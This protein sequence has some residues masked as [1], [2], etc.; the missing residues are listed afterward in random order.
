MKITLDKSWI[1]WYNSRMVGKL[2]NKSPWPHS[3]AEHTSLYNDGRIRQVA[4]VLADVGKAH[5]PNVR[6]PII[7]GG[8]IRDT[9][10]G[11][12]YKDIDVFFDVSS[13]AEDERDDAV[14]LYASYVLDALKKQDGW[15]G[16]KLARVQALSK[17]AMEGYENANWQTTPFYVYETAPSEAAFDIDFLEV[18]EDVFEVEP[19]QFIGHVDPRLSEDPK[20][21]VDSF[22]YNMVK[23]FFDTNTME[24]IFSTAFLEGLESKRIEY[25][26]AT[27][28]ARI[29]RFDERFRMQGF[30][31]PF[32]LVNNQPADRIP[33][34]NMKRY[35]T[36]SN[37]FHDWANAEQNAQ[38][39]IR[40]HQWAFVE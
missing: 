5:F 23:A 10:F 19:I 12:D 22:D 39:F 28:Y 11:L 9:V 34:P 6:L 31:S 7:A 13:V 38:R 24:Y 2:M 29:K 21:F 27:A 35:Y 20:A 17:K 14:L 18:D 4:N 15:G 8:S 3:L 40:G 32:E 26:N 25:E 36:T 37:K 30:E 33:I 1:P 16:L